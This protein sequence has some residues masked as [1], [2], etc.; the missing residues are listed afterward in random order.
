MRPARHRYEGVVFDDFPTAVE[1]LRIAVQDRATPDVVRLTDEP[2]TNLADGGGESGGRRAPL[3]RQFLRSRRGV[4]VIVGWEGQLDAV[5]RRRLHTMTLLRR[6]GGDADRRDRRARMGGDAL[7]A[8]L[9]ARRAARPRRARRPVRDRDHLDGDRG[10]ARGGDR[11]DRERAGGARDAARWSAARSRTSTSPAPRSPSRC[12][13]AP[14][15]ARRRRSGAPPRTP[16]ARRSS[17][18]GATISHHHG[19]G[20]DHADWVGAELGPLGSSSLAA[21]KAHLDPTG[22][23]NPGKLIPAL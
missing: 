14:S 1:A 19:I 7:R 21:L 16:R 6:G 2:Q 17:R 5:D 3:G 12:S 20:R 23:M 15:A 13:R 10:A 18:V 9:R 8:A 22:V 11:R 4:L